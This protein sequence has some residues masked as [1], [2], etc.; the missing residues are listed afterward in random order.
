MIGMIWLA[1]IVSIWLLLV[2]GCLLFFH[3]VKRDQERFGG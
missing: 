2:C 3:N 1:V